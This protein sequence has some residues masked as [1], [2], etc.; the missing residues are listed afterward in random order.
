MSILPCSP[1][2]TT[3]IMLLLYYLLAGTG[4]QLILQDRDLHT[5]IPV[6]PSLIFPNPIPR[7]G[8]GLK[9]MSRHYHVPL[10]PSERN[11]I[12]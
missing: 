11:D 1:N 5:P 8:V 3:Y 12:A 7:P 2:W 9:L 4:L 10:P 6:G